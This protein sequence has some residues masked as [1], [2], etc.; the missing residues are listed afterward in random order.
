GKLIP[1][2]LPQKNTAFNFAFNYGDP[3]TQTVSAVTPNLSQ[4]LTFNIGA[5]SAIQPNSVELQ[6]PVSSGVG[7]MV[8]QTVTLFDV[9]LNSTTGNLV[10]R[11]GNVQGTITYATGAVEVTPIIN[12]S[13]WQTIYSPQTY[14]VSS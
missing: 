6:I 11:L 5:G 4:K 10:D 1:N 2:K 8:F 12:V 14:Y 9:P 3:K 7:S 13:S